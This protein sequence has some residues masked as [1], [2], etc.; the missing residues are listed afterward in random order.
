M[1]EYQD[2]IQQLQKNEYK[3]L[4]LL[5]G[6]EAYFIDKITDYITQNALSEAEK[7]F[8]QTIYYGKDVNAGIILE[9]AKRYPMMAEK[10]VVIVREAQDLKDLDALEGY[11]ENPVQTTILVLAYK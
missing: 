2:I 11:A 7:G 5:F 4:Y 3:P 1:K 9:T 6:S 8:N 10:Q